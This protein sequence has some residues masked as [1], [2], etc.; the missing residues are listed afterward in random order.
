MDQKIYKDKHPS[1]FIIG[2]IIRIIDSKYNS[3]I[4]KIFICLD[5][6]QIKDIP[7]SNIYAVQLNNS[8]YSPPGTTWTNGTLKVDVELI[9]G[10][11]K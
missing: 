7:S 2:S 8:I 3:I 10:S 6:I 11:L 1:D 5:N 9:R 4:G